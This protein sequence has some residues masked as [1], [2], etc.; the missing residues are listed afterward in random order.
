M[1]YRIVGECGNCGGDVVL[2]DAWMSVNPQ[3]PHC[4]KCGA[5]AKQDRPVLPMTPRRDAAREEPK[6]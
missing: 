4:R 1:S 3:V 6:R 2:E 5:H